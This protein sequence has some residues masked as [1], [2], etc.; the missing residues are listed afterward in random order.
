M[1]WRGKDYVVEVEVQE[2]LESVKADKGPLLRYVVGAPGTFCAIFE[3]V[4]TGINGGVVPLDFSCLHGIACSATSAA[5]AA[6]QANLES[7]YRVRRCWNAEAGQCGAG[8][9]TFNEPAASYVRLFLVAHKI[10]LM[11]LL[12]CSL[13]S[14]QNTRYSEQPL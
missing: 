12:G 6:D 14:G 8:C 9:R 11:W 2:L 3:K 13:S 1:W 7:P 4:S 10:L 5:T